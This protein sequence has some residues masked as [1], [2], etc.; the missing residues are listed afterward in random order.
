MACFR[1]WINFVFKIVNATQFFLYF[2]LNCFP[3]DDTDSNNKLDCGIF[4]LQKM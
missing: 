3:Q 4:H 1:T 2:D